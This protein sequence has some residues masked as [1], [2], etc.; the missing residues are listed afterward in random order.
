MIILLFIII[1]FAAFFTEQDEIVVNKKIVLAF[2]CF[3]MSFTE[4]IR[5][6]SGTDY[7]QYYNFFHGD[8]S[9]F[10][11]NHTFEPLYTIIVFLFQKVTNSFFWFDLFYFILLYSLYFFSLPKITNKYIVAFFL[12]FC[13]NIGFLGS[14][15]QLMA[16]GISFFATVYFLPKEKLY[17]ILW[18]IVAS[19]FHYSAL[20]T[21]LFVFLDRKIP[22]KFLGIIF[23]V[24]II[25]LFTNLNQQITSYFVF[26]SHLKENYT[27]YFV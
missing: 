16:L 15:R 24:F 8:F 14:N 26:L 3:L 7:W 18:V 17:F 19:L 13:M 23:S 1:F 20:I 25:L 21:L 11:Q 5:F 27:Y 2:L 10:R 12:I 9:E 6:K 22:E 4:A